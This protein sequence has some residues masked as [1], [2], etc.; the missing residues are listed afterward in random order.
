MAKKLN[1][2]SKV[3]SDKK[4]GVKAAKKTVVK[5]VAATNSPSKRVVKTKPIKT[6]SKKAEAK[7]ETKKSISKKVSAKTKATVKNT[8]KPIMKKVDKSTNKKLTTTKTKNNKTTKAS[9]K[10]AQTVKSISTK[11]NK[12]ENK[13][14]TVRAAASK[15]SSKKVVKGIKNTGKSKK[16]EISA[17]KVIA[18]KKQLKN[19]QQAVKISV[20]QKSTKVKKEAGNKSTINSTKKIAAKTEKIKLPKT[21]KNS[22]VEKE[23]K[24]VLP[25]EDVQ[26]KKAPEPVKKEKTLGESILDKP[27]DISLLNLSAEALPGNKVV[28][29]ARSIKHEVTDNRTRYSDEELQEFKE[30]ILKKLEEAQRDYEI[31]KDTLSHKDDHGTDDT[32]PTFKLIEDGSD[33]LSREETAQLAG[34]QLKFIESLK[35]ALIRIENKT[36]GICRVTGKLI[37]KERLR[38][39]PH[40]TLSV[41]AKLDQNNH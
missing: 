15:A 12:Q 26:I 9:V 5:K 13:K 4:T 32:S 20:K 30:I 29:P 6:A 14:T 16:T 34:R 17:K 2:Q 31:L 10:K 7:V 41:E 39:V 25:K 3:K 8:A 37:S 11:Q 21:T 27:V 35:N 1:A 36:Y 28:E 24:V 38:S 23:S 33:V 22:K 19:K 18:N 40:A